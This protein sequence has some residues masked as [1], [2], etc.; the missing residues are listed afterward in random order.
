MPD[1]FFLSKFQYIIFNPSRLLNRRINSDLLAQ[2]YSLNS[3]KIYKWNDLMLI[4]FGMRSFLYFLS[5][6]W[7]W[8][9]YF[10]V[11][12][13]FCVTNGGT[14]NFLNNPMKF[15]DFLNSIEN[16]SFNAKARNAFWLENNVPSTA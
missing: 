1:E 6:C 3:I 14:D 4:T 2:D 12:L 11:L 15:N 8:L 5:L 16:C 10:L 9:L 13:L 7:L